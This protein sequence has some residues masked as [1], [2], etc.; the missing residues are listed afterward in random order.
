MRL[1]VSIAYDGTRFRGSARQP[2]VATVEGSIIDRLREMEAIEST[3]AGRFQAASR[4]DAGVSA[5]GN[6]VA[7]DTEMR[8]DSV[9]NGLAYGLEDVW[10]LRY[11][12]VDDDFTPRHARRKTYR[13]YL[14]DEGYDWKAMQQAAHFFEGMHDFSAFARLDGRSP[15]RSIERVI[16]NGGE[17]LTIDVTGSSFLWQQ[18]RRMVA[19]VIQVGRGD[20]SVMVIQEALQHPAGQDFGLASP[21]Q[22]LLLAVEYPDTPA[23]RKAPGVEKLKERL[24]SLQ[25]RR[26]MYVDMTHSAHRNK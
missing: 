15:L 18:V 14:Y 20:L 7:F 10:P 6:V 4:T 13:Y 26:H 16:L 11:A 8:P 21:E 19:A 3:E 25:A 23:W 22:L 12:V 24:H 1:A 2:G 9:V 5:A 17:V